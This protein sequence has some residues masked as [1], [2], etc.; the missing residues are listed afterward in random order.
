MTS[1]LT[2]SPSQAEVQAW[3][4]VPTLGP[5]EPP[6]TLR[7]HIPDAPPSWDE[8][9]FPHQ[10]DVHFLKWLYRVRQEAGV[11]IR[12]NDDYRKPQDST[13]VSASAHKEAPCRAVDVQV[14]SS[15]DRGK[16]VIAAIILGCRRVGPYPGKDRRGEEGWPAYAN[17]ASG[18]HLDC[19]TS[20]PSPR[21]WTKY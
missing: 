2:R 19:S 7:E 16:I 1:P 6:E 3:N 9:D 17:D 12:L 5:E 11:P 20:K 10:M 13:G 15:L 8:F 4:N 21:M 18:L 14:Y